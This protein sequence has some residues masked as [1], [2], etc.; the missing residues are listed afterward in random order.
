M[1]IVFAGDEASCLFS[2][3]HT[4]THTHT[5]AHTH[6]KYLK[7]KENDNNLKEIDGPNLERRKKN[8]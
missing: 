8:F 5:H 1:M 6:N 3:T 4:H 7:R 2:Q